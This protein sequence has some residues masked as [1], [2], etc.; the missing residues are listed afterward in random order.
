[1]PFYGINEK[2]KGYKRS[3][4][5]TTLMLTSKDIFPSDRQTCKEYL[6]KKKTA[7]KGRIRNFYSCKDN[8]ALIRKI[9]NTLLQAILWEVATGKCSFKFP[10]NSKAVIFVGEL[11][12]AI[13]RSKV[14]HGKLGYVDMTQT[15]NTVPYLTFRF[16]PRQKKKELKIYVPKD[17]YNNMV[18]HANSGEKFSVRPRSIDYFLPYLY[19]TFSYIQEDKVKKLVVHCFNLL[20]EELKRGEEVRFIDKT[21]EVRFFR[22][23]GRFHDAIMKKVVKKRLQ[24]IHKEKYEQFYV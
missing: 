18:A 13:V 24:R 14:K 9:F 6:V 2:G 4:Y 7:P 3:E 15:N 8:P 1:M 21:G 22:A 16:A 5:D 17:I 19:D 11:N 23:L 20:L 10:G 12:D